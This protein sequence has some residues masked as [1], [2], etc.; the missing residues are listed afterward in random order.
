MSIDDPTGPSWTIDGPQSLTVPEQRRL[1]LRVQRGEIDVIG[2]D[3]QGAR[4]DVRDV[5]G[6]PLEVVLED[7]VLRIGAQD[8]RDGGTRASLT[9]AVQHDTEV[10]VEVVTAEVLVSGMKQGCRIGTVSGGVVCDATAGSARLE[11]TSGEL[12][13]REHEGAVEVRTVSGAIT[14]SG[15]VTRFDCDSVSADLFLDLE[16]PDLVRLRTVSGAVVLRLGP[17]RPAEY[18]ID[19]ISGGLEVDGQDV[20]RARHGFRG[21]WGEAGAEPTRVRVETAS[22]TVRVVHSADV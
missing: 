10:D 16:A 7:G 9:V 1:R 4:I 22:G 12:A 3:E 17:D 21:T 2:C 14:A 8:G 15:A 13:L 11:G 6:P 5:S 18:T 20:G 19:T